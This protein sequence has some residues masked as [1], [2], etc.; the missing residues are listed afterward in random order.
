M[1]SVFENINLD[2]TIEHANIKEELVIKSQKNHQ[3][4]I[5]KSRKQTNYWKMSCLCIFPNIIDLYFGKHQNCAGHHVS[6]RAP[7]TK[8]LSNVKFKNSFT[9]KFKEKTQIMKKDTISNDKYKD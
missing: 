9:T 1:K 2:I 7:Q 5:K 8:V 3:I 6:Q 4:T